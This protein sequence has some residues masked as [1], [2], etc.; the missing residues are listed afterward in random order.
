MGLRVG[1][2]AGGTF[3]DLIARDSQSGQTYSHK[4]ASTPRNPADAIVRGVDELTQKYDLGQTEIELMAHGTTVGTNTL[5]QRSGARIALIT[6]KGFRDLLEIGRQTRPI[7]YNMHIDFPPPVVPRHRRIE[8]TERIGSSGEVVTEVDPEELEFVVRRAL[9]DDPEAIAVCF[10]FGYL[11]PKHEQE[12]K[13]RIL[14]AAPHMFLSLSSEV[15]PEFRE[16]ERISTTVIN[17]YLQPV[18]ARYLNSLSRVS[19]RVPA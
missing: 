9:Q 13:Q 19:W 16:Y 3:T 1:I 4:L 8:I 12:V 7:N 14:S 6:T 17:A 15:Q 11:N 5:L 2:D 18:M 10:L